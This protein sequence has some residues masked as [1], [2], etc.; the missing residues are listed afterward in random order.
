MWNFN[1]KVFN[2][3]DEILKFVNSDEFENYVK[4]EIPKAKIQEYTHNL[5]YIEE[6]ESEVHTSLSVY[7]TEPEWKTL[8][9]YKIHKPS[10]DADPTKE[11]EEN[12]ALI[13]KITRSID[14]KMFDMNIGY[15]PSKKITTNPDSENLPL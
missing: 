5:F 12:M 9:S 6:T 7:A 4:G 2:D 3:V 1:N 14:S 8:F 15:H 13:E 11:Q 10:G